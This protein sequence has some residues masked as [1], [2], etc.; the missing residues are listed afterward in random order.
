M[1]MRKTKVPE[2]MTTPSRFFLKILSKAVIDVCEKVTKG[3]SSPRSTFLKR[4]EIKTPIKIRGAHS[5]K[6]NGILNTANEINITKR[7]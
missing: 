6:S 7:D 2:T 3:I 5:T 1:G 4:G